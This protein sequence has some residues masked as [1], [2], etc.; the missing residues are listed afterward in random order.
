[1]IA[2]RDKAQS[3]GKQVVPD[4]YQGVSKERVRRVLLAIDQANDNKID[5]IFS[6]L[7]DEQSWYPKAAKQGLRFCDGA[8]VAHIGTHVG[9]LQRGRNIKLDREGRDYWLKPFW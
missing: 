3:K 6:L 4:S 2:R 5:V 7:C 1:M 8:S 9:I